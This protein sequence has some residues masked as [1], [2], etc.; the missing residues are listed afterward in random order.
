MSED[1]CV[2]CGVTIPEGEQVCRGCVEESER[3]FIY[4][5]TERDRYS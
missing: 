2:C 3:G 5:E 1:K 4:V